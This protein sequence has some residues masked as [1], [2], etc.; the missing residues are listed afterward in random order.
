MM[1]VRLTVD[2]YPVQDPGLTGGVDLEE[3]QRMKKQVNWAAHL[4]LFILV[5]VAMFGQ[6]G[7]AS[8]ATEQ[9]LSSLQAGDTVSFA[10]YTWIVLNPSTGY[11]LMRNFYDARTGNK[12]AEKFD[13]Q[14]SNTFNPN[15]SYNIASF[16][17]RTN[18]DGGFSGTGFYKYLSDNY[19]A[20]I[21]LIQ[22]HT[23]T[24][25]PEG[26]ESASSSV[27]CQIGLLSYSEYQQ[28]QGVP[29]VKADTN[30]GSWWLR[31]TSDSYVEVANWDGSRSACPGNW[32]NYVRP[33]LYLNPDIL[34]SD[35]NVTTTLDTASSLTVATSTNTPTAGT[36]FNV[37]VTAKDSNGY[38]MSGY[39]GSVHFSSTDSNAV[40][41][42]DYT[43]VSGDNGTHTFSGGATLETAGTQ[44]VT[45]TDTVTNTITGTSGSL[46]VNFILYT[47]SIDSTIG[48]SITASPTSATLGTAIT[49]TITPD[50]GMQLRAGSLKYSDGTTDHAISG[51]SFAIPATNVTVTAQFEPVPPS[52]YTV[53]FDSQGGSAVSSLCNVPPGST[54]SAPTTPTQSGYTFG[55]WYKEANCTNAWN[56]NSDTVINNITLYAKWTAIPGPII[57]SIAP[58]SGPETGGTSITITG[59]GFTGATAVNFGGTVATSYSVTTDSAIIATS[60][61]G[62]GTVDVRVT[63]PGG[64][65]AVVPSDQFAYAAQNQDQAAPTGLTGI[66]PTTTDNNDGKITGVS[67]SMEYRLQGATDFTPVTSSSLEITGLAAGTYQIRYAARTGYN[68]GATVDVVVP[69]YTTPTFLSLGDSIAYGMSAAAGSDYTHLFYNHLL[70]DPAYNQL[71]LNN[72]A[73]SGDKSSDLLQRLL[74]PQYSTAVGNANVI[75]I[76]IGGDNLLS[77][78]IASVCT[79]F[80]VN[81][82]NNPNLTTQ[83]A[84]AMAA[85]PNKDVILASLA[86]SPALSQALQSGVTQFSTDFP[87]IIATVK[88]LA[89]QAQ[90]YVLNLY[91]P[92]SQQDPLY[93]VFDPLIKGINQ[94]ISNNAAAGYKVADVYTMFKATPGAVNFNLATLQLDPHPTTAGHAAIYQA[95]LDAE[96]GQS[97]ATYYT[98]S[99]GSLTGGSI[100]ANP[101]SATSGSAINLTIT[102]DSGMQLMPGTLKYNDGR[103]HIIT[104]TSFTMPA[105]NVVVS[106]VFEAVPNSTHEGGGGG[107]FSGGSSASSGGS[108]VT[109]S[110]INGTTGATV[111][112]LTGTVTIDSNGNYAVSMQAAQTLSFQ[113]SDGTSSPLSDLT[114]VSYVS[115]ADSSVAVSADGTINFANLAKGTDNQYKITYDL[116]N[117]QTITLGTLEITVSSSGTV[118]LK[119]TLIDPYGI[120]TDAATGKPVVGTKVT[121]Y[122]AN[123]ERNKTN[124]KTPDTVVTLQ[125]ID[126]FK[127]NNNQNPQTSDAKGAYGFMVFPDTD[128]YIVASKEGYESYT[129]PTISVGQDIVHWDFEMNTPINGVNRL[130]GQN[131]VDTALAIAKANYTGTLS[132]VVL[133]TAGNYPDALAG[134]VLAYKLNAPILL[135]GSS[136]ADQAKVLDYMK[137][138]LATSGNVYIL[139]GTAVVSADMEAKIKADGFSQISRLGGTDRYKTS[140]KIADQ[141]Q[142]KSG[143][144]IVLAFGENY[145]DALSISS[146]AAESQ[147]PILL[148]QKDEISDVVKNEIAAIKPSKVYIIGGEGVISSAVES[149]VEQIT[150]LD[151]TNIIRIAGQD[152]YDTSLAVAQYF[153]LA[154]QSVCIATGNN[155]PDAL[156][157]SVY[158]AN[159]NTSIVLADGS[160]S[161]QVVNYLKGKKLTGV[162]IFGGEAVV[163]K[164]IEQQLSQ[165]IGN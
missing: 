130:A 122:Y 31:T 59:T 151:K 23:W 99:I 117:G 148:V 50:S 94:A 3:E 126:G 160:L 150:S 154:G 5:T 95:L 34:I 136:E 164:G 73:V 129:S 161:D 123:T 42:A 20:D 163:R 10:G 132:N 51:T 142:V 138:N 27:P 104:G 43:F 66:A 90:I 53:T 33:A 60:P 79:A 88:T 57:T 107:S 125:G 61:A 118:S 48:G 110:V 139:G 65:S 157:G 146:V 1:S 147:Y 75:T 155:F 77:P 15:D 24:T 143:T 119:C 25:G 108:T 87:Q 70:S 35:S 121:L 93:T 28:Y 38:T 128:Y 69:A 100:T 21:S 46:T 134:S 8:A 86:T 62:S 58:T 145:P 144:P 81:P 135:V 152:R 56:F 127:P 97:P 156:A 45:A 80:G 140:V 153:N 54:I 74:T 105:A 7:S 52:M 91:N 78:V 158:A 16:L 71:V 85:N 98:V 131:Q 84:A 102:P 92:F 26:S 14:G 36:A 11:L 124:G 112:N 39:T 83:L 162:T 89:P 47:V 41:P 19:P 165:L 82:V 22:N 141:L 76:S 17:N 55:G 113:Q 63:T 12:C 68:A 133:A 114:K 96:S 44:T 13:I 120:I 30:T 64:T 37:T 159:H 2:K 115:A 9:P 103:D 32:T 106:A 40:L 67:D 137:S 101:T 116:G 29:G 111:S 4:L 6:P 49:L 109:G 18:Y 149:Q 72:L